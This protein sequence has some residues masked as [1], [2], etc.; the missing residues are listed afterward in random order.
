MK[1][2]DHTPG[3]NVMSGQM[4]RIIVGAVLFLA[5]FSATRV[6]A[7]CPSC[8]GADGQRS[9]GGSD[10]QRSDRWT[11]FK[12]SHECYTHHN[13]DF[14]CGSW[15]SETTFIFGSCRAFFGDPCFDGPPGDGSCP[16]RGH[17]YKNAFPRP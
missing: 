1:M 13:S 5:W 8:G 9:G 12:P 11:W 14:K 2:R 16:P 6:Q 10:G 7:Q 17:L 4:R 15:R 3:G